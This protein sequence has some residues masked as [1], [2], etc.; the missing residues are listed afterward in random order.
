M[1]IIIITATKNTTTKGRH[2]PGMSFWGFYKK[3][4][5]SAVPAPDTTS[6]HADP[7]F[8]LGGNRRVAAG[9]HHLFAGRRNWRQ[10][11]KRAG[12]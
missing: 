1:A 5:G 10:I 3:T 2:Q 4:E 7:S 11:W 9:S 8:D 6:S 12:V